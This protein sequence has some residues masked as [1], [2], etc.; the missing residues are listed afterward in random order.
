MSFFFCIFAA[1]F[2]IMKN[3]VVIP[4]YK[5]QIS[6]WEEMSLRQCCKVL[7]NHAI[8]LV[9]H[10]GLDCREY[11]R[12]AQEFNIQLLREN[13][14]AYYFSGIPGYNALMM[15]KEFYLRFKQ[16]DYMLV[17]Q[18]DAYVFRDELDYWCDKG[19]DYIGAP[20]F[21]NCDSHEE[22]VELWKVGNGGLSLRRIDTHIRVLTRKLPVLGLKELVGRSAHMSFLKR[23]CSIFAHLIGWHNTI[24][25]FVRTYEHFEDFFWCEK[26]PSLSLDYKIPSAQEAVPFSFELSPAYLY[27]LNNNTLPFGCHAWQKYEYESFWKKY[28][29]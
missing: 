17:Y 3:I 26:I 22:E 9:T 29:H 28:I 7:S 4:V 13:F 2:E 11:Y 14:D 23:A 5:Q 12:I 20:W 10:E 19:Y 8:C 27:E 16:Y 24:D 1:N 25:Y 18:L 15:S 6:E 21:F